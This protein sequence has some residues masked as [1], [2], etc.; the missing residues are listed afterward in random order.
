[1]TRSA[2]VAVLLFVLT[3]LVSGQVPVPFGDLPGARAVP[4]SARYVT[5]RSI[6]S[7]TQ[8]VSGG[9]FHVAL[10]LNIADGWVYYS[11]D[12][13]PIVL[14][15]SLEVDAEKL[16]PG[17]PLFPKDKPKTVA[18]GDESVTNNVYTGRT[19][20]YVPI[21]VP[22]GTEEGTYRITLIPRGQICQA[23]CLNLDGLEASVS[24]RVGPESIPNPLWT[25]DVSGGL[26][27][28]VT[29]EQ[30]KLLHAEPPSA[31]S[32]GIIPS[33]PAAGTVWA[34]IGLALLAGLTL[35]IMP[36]VLPVIPLRILSIVA[37]AKESRRRFVTL[38]LTFAAG[39]VL[40]F[41]GLA[42]V[43]AILHLVIG[44][45]LNVSDHFT[46]PP[47]RIAM[48]MVLIA[49][50]ANLFGVFTVTVPSRV[51]S[52]EGRQV[53][54]G[55][56]K[57][58]GMG[59]MMAVLATPCSFAYLLAAMAWAQVQPLWLGTLGILL[60][61][62]G[63]AA[64]HILLCAFPDLLKRLPKP[65]RWM[66]LFK[67]AMGFCLLPVA[68][69]LISTL[70]EDSWPFWVA[71]YGVVLAFCLWGWANW[72]RYD[73]PRV[74]KLLVRALV[75]AIAVAA[76]FAMLTRPAPPALDFEEFDEALIA[77]ERARGRV[78]LVKVTASWCTECHLI[79]YRVYNTPEIADEIAQRNVL[80]VEAD[81]TNRSSPASRWARREFNAAPP[82]TVVY[83]S[84]G[85]DPIR[86]VG[87]F[88]RSDLT[89]VLD[90]AAGRTAS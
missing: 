74:R 11:P 31:R 24:V 26:D 90:E 78:V 17:P 7:H 5:A 49:L 85:G 16:A 75:L 21:S 36:C 63:M 3:G 51:A 47:V 37:M 70:S 77:A 14:A 28:A 80:A 89:K 33:A 67:H 38:G 83:P 30:L 52:L 54:E 44:T 29:V 4:E 12:P 88:T 19:L 69:W 32:E 35:N 79:D 64:P 6:A 55:H 42:L 58:V 86:L 73:A 59:L 50:S 20:I 10:D 25:A 57:A 45:G 18:F 43:N 39:M 84:D 66:E 81:I 1:M 15:G 40:F 27:D 56:V 71:A 2:S 68:I 46:Y 87:A 72:V 65:G 23:V 48:A 13:G 61:G 9:R 8:V 53:R 62:V 41:A 22:D 82:L 34:G 60:I 76:G